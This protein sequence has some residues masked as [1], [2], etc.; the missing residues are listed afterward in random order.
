[1]RRHPREVGQLLVVPNTKKAWAQLMCWP[2]DYCCLLSQGVGLVCRQ[3]HEWDRENGGKGINLVNIQ[4][5][6]K[7]I[8][9]G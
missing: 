6:E 3:E 5:E 7:Y 9:A 2:T 1:M 8:Q 4:S